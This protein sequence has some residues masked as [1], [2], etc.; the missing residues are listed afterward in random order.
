MFS[1]WLKQNNLDLYD[2]YTFIAKFIGTFSANFLMA[3]KQ[4]LQT[5]SLFSDEFPNQRMDAFS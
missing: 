5:F 3:E 4:T 1:H 2:L